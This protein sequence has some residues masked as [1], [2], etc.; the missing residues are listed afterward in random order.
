MEQSKSTDKTNDF[1]KTERQKDAINLLAGPGR[2][3]MIYGG[4][5]S[6]KTFILCYALIV[7]A[8]KCKSRHVIL[9][10][11]FNH[12]KT[13]IWLDTLPK[14]LGLCFPDL[15]VRWNK[16]DYF[17]TLPNG[18]EIWIAGLDTK[19]RTE[20]ILGKEYSTMYFNECSQLTFESVSMALTRL[21][22][23]SDLTKKAY[24]D[25]NPPTKR[26]WSYW[27]FIRHWHPINEEEVDMHEYASML[28]NPKDN[29]ENIDDEYISAILDKLPERDRARFRDGL[30]IDGDDGCAYY[31]F[32]R[33]ENVGEFDGCAGSNLVGMDFNV[34][35]MTAVIAKMK[36]GKLYIYDE[37]FQRNSDTFKAA[38]ELKEKTSG[39][40]YIYPD[41]TG[42]NRKTSGKSDFHIL[43]DCFGDNAI[44]GTSNPFV[45][46]RVNNLNRLFEEKRII[47]HPR[48]RKL[49][50][51]LEK[52]SWKDN[53]LDQKT[54]PLLTHISDA[55]GY[56]AWSVLPFEH[57]YNA[58]IRLR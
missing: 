30:F 45:N 21:A 39:Q 48:C 1:K 27:L 5:R 47:I 17:L 37:V 19:E 12:V 6:G 44:E 18:S 4:S 16:S 31:S 20:K 14:V 8:S 28:I 25:E 22:E 41:S 10:E 54:E 33:E 7:R 38:K 40:V 32:S 58:K 36:N 42:K 29:L 11:K 57:V 51:D 50:N 34:D 52:V 56:L 23:K 26:H 55:L 9:R 46:D 3:V 13:S 35:P 15:P 2:H 24:Y 43:E 49:I 53:K